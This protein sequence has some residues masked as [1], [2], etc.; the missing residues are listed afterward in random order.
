LQKLGPNSSVLSHLPQSMKYVARG[1]VDHRRAASAWAM[2]ATTWCIPLKEDCHQR[3]QPSQTLF[4]LFLQGGAEPLL[5][6]PSANV[7]GNGRLLF[8]LDWL[9]QLMLHSLCKMTIKPIIPSMTVF[10][11]GCSLSMI[12]TYPTAGTYPRT[13]PMMS[14]FLSR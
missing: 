13:L 1:P 14:S 12:V 10:N 4:G 3:N 5:V 11:H 7:A 6:H 8:G 2:P 9:S